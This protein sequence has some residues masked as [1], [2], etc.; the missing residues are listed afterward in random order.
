M[1][2]SLFLVL[3]FVAAGLGQRA[4]AA[5]PACCWWQ[6]LWP[7]LSRHCPCCLDDYCPKAY[8]PNPCPVPCCGPDDYCAKPLP[9]TCPAKYC[10]VND[11]CRKACPI[12]LPSCYP[13]WYTCGCP[14][15]KP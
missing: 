9:L 8:P 13:S 14:E 5:E 10:G 4:G 15:G 2:Q 7:P 11:Y 3:L 12:V 6:S 1:R